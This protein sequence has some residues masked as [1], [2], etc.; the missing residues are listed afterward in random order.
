MTKYFSPA[1]CERRSRRARPDRTYSAR[2]NTSRATNS[3]TRSLAVASATIPTA[4]NSSSGST[5]ARL[6]W[7][8]LR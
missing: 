8:S 7:R 4:A 1:S 3:V 5:S 6:I 2:E